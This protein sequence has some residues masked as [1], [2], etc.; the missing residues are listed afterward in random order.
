MNFAGY[1][2]RRMLY[3]VCNIIVLKDS[4]Y[5]YGYNTLYDWMIF[6]TLRAGSSTIARLPSR[7][8]TS[9][10]LFEDILILYRGILSRV[11]SVNNLLTVKCLFTMSFY[12]MKK[13]KDDPVLCSDIS[14]WFQLISYRLGRWSILANNYENQV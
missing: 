6:F 7:K 10:E 14:R 8:Q 9:E 4:N 3:E 13:Y 1:V 2:A 11:D 5:E 12:M